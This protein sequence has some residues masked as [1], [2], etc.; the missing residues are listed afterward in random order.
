[1]ARSLNQAE[2]EETEPVEDGLAPSGT[3]LSEPEVPKVIRAQKRSVR[4]GVTPVGTNPELVES[5]VRSEESQALQKQLLEELDGR[6]LLM[7]VGRT[8]YTKGMIECLDAFERLL[9]R[10]P[11]LIGEVKM[12]VTSVRA[13]ST[14]KIYEETQ[15]DIEGLVGRI[16]GRFS[17]L[18]WTPVV[19]FSNAIPF[20]RLVA[21]FRVADVCVTTPL[22]DGLNLVAKEFVAAKQGQPGTLIL[23]EFAGCAVELPRAVLTNPYSNRDMDRALDEAIDMPKAEAQK[24]IAEMSKVVR[25]YDLARGA[26]QVAEQ[27]DDITAVPRRVKARAAA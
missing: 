13:A 15:R 12:L 25:H 8:D 10:R 1:V 26:S 22:R 6:R 19:L 4:L 14:M 23:S 5:Y 3:A 7:T 24:R 11:E 16:N 20:E 9:E 18:D 17:K 27:F 2:V 21:H